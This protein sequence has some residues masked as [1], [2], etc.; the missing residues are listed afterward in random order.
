LIKRQDWLHHAVPFPAFKK[1]IAWQAFVIV[2]TFLYIGVALALGFPLA[3]LGLI[4]VDPQNHA[5]VI[6][7][8]TTPAICDLRESR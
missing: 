3:R 1:V 7:V 4:L 5:S 6:L 2:Y 8:L